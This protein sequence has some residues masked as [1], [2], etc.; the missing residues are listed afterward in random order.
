VI[1]EK[2]SIFWEV[3][4]S[5]IV[6]KK[7]KLIWTCL[8]VAR[9]SPLD[10]CLWR[11]MKSEVYKRKVDTRGELLARVLATAARITEREDH[12]RRKR[13]DLRT[14]IAQCIDADGGIFENLL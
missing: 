3:T 2:R 7:T 14:R 4:V 5:V 10:F 9:Q 6:G 11:W 12:L 13:R 1:Q 8:N